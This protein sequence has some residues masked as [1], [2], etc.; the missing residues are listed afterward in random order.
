MEKYD[1][2]R[3]KDGVE[4]LTPLDAKSRWKQKLKFYQPLGIPKKFDMT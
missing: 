3:I 2:R 1:K 4:F